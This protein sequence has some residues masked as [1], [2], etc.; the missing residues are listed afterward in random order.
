MYDI[1]WVFFSDRFFGSNVMLRVAE[2]KVPQSAASESL[3]RLF[4]MLGVSPLHRAGPYMASFPDLPIAASSSPLSSFHLSPVRTGINTLPCSHSMFFPCPVPK[5]YRSYTFRHI[6]PS[7][8][9]PMRSTSR[10]LKP[11]PRAWTHQ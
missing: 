5:A 7:A 6:T 1:F 4:A 2:Q 8:P 10:R 9:P 3:P 11:W